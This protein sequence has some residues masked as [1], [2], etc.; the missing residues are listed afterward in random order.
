MSDV[1]DF[2]TYVM[3]YL[4]K[5][6]PQMQFGGETRE[7]WYVWQ[8]RLRTKLLDLMEPFPEQVPLEARVTEERQ[9]F[10]VHYE[11][12]VYTTAED[13]QVPAWLL[14]PEDVAQP[15]P[16]IICL[17]GHGVNGKDN[18]AHVDYGE[19]DRATAIKRANYDYGLQ[20][21]KRGFVTLCPDARGFGERREDFRRYGNRDGCNVNGIKTFLLGMNLAALNTWDDMRGLDY[22]A[23]RPEVDADRLGCIGLSFGGTR[24]MY[25]AAVDEA[26]VSVCDELVL[27][28]VHNLI[29]KPGTAIGDVCV[30]YS[31][32]QALGQCRTYLER[33]LPRAEPRASLSTAAAVLEMERSPAVAAAISTRRAADLYGAELL[34]EEIQDNAN[35]ATRFLVLAAQDSAP[36]G[37]DRTSICFSFAEDK[38]GQLFGIMRVMAEREINLSKVESRPTREGLGQY[39]FLL[40]LEG[41][42]EDSSIRTAL[43]EVARSTSMLKVFGSYP[44]FVVPEEAG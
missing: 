21:A 12:V 5:H 15:A 8:K 1:F 16:G 2:D 38:P 29:G 22:L 36:T 23:S 32:P 31:H 37:C 4:E 40:D 26:G 25:L 28:I 34:A 30:V 35:N 10:G 11:K 3:A 39:Y 18:V 9:Q 33:A 20:L 27:P 41:H 43:E 44:R 7:Q 42:R 6:P 19:E 17:H 14:I 24:S 13:V